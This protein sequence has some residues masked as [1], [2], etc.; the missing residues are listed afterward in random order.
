[1]A[2]IP[3]SFQNLSLSLRE[4][5]TKKWFDQAKIR[6]S[7]ARIAVL[8][9]PQWQS[10]E[11]WLFVARFLCFQKCLGSVPFN[12][13][14]HKP[15]AM[16]GRGPT[17]LGI[18]DLRSPMAYQPPTW[19]DPP[20]T[21]SDGCLGDF[22][23]LFGHVFWQYNWNFTKMEDSKGSETI[24]IFTGQYLRTLLHSGFTLIRADFA[25]E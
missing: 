22:R 12:I 6:T 3:K 1:M 8:H 11:L 10:K 18:G 20:S 17:T 2:S 9:S 25:W 15:R 13:Y 7:K 21:M 16:E 23:Y 24:K 19:D 14:S 4:N 5:P